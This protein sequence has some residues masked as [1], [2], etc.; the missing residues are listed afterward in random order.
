MVGSQELAH[1]RQ[2]GSRLATP[3]SEAN[4]P[5][6]KMKIRELLGREW[7]VVGTGAL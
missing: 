4:S 3:V 2:A 6:K 5:S 7:M 1:L